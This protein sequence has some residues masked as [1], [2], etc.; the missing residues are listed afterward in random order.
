MVL[1]GHAG[2]PS[3]GH[4]AFLAAGCHTNAILMDR[5]GL[6][7]LASFTLAGLLRARGRARRNPRAAAA[8]HL[9]R[10][11]HPGPV[12]PDRGHHRP[13]RAVDRWCGRAER[14]DDL[15]RRA[16]GGPLRNARSL[17]LALPGGGAAGHPRLPQ[18]PARTA[19]EGL[20]GDPG[21][22]GVGAGDGGEPR[23]HQGRRVRA[24]LHGDGEGRR[25]D[26]TLLLPRRGTEPPGALGLGNRRPGHRPHLPEHRALRALDGA[27]QPARRAPRAPAGFHR[28]A[29]PL[30]S[31]RASRGDCAPGRGRAGHR[32]PRSPAAPRED[33]RV[34]PVRRAQGGRDRPGAGHGAEARPA[35]RVRLRTLAREGRVHAV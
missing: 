30:H 29:D 11:R 14:T 22:G 2:Q 5:F 6:P 19:R 8:R 33:D 35:R 20:H 3:L 12:D 10:H 26:G 24:L 15:H 32:L 18:H 34:A 17:L 1:R 31:C 21:L 28:G 23:P 13:G 9:P 7:F 27:A 25:P 16:G 4:A